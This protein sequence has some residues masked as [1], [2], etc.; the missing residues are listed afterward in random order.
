MKK[1][2]VILTL[3]I[4]MLSCTNQTSKIEKAQEFKPYLDTV[5]GK[6]VSNEI[7]MNILFHQDYYSVYYKIQYP[8]IDSSLPKEYQPYKL[9]DRLNFRSNDEVIVYLK[10]HY[11]NKKDSYFI[12]SCYYDNNVCETLMEIPYKIDSIGTI[13]REVIVRYK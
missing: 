1:V 2:I 12:D 3:I 7:R 4:T 11:E 9:N 13:K 6:V 5:C 8:I 10:H